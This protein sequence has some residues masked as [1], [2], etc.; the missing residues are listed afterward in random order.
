MIVSR[1]F[2][3]SSRL[4]KGGRGTPQI[5]AH[6]AM[7][8]FGDTAMNDGRQNTVSTLSFRRRV[9][10]KEENVLKKPTRS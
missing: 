2:Q 10:R 7:Y 3:N 4:K 8:A 1:C 6:A 5:S 9:G